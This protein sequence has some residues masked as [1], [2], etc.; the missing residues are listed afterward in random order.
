MIYEY[1]K[2]LNLPSHMHGLHVRMGIA[3]QTIL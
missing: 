3:L 1:W 2:Q